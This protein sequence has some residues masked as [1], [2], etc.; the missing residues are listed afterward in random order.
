MFLAHHQESPIYHQI[1]IYE[2]LYLQWRIQESDDVYAHFRDNEMH[3][4][5][6]TKLVCWWWFEV[7][8]LVLGQ[9]FNGSISIFYTYA[10]FKQ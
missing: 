8:G 5:P 6:C 9:Y 10:D 2:S 1:V 4:V 3:C 7:E